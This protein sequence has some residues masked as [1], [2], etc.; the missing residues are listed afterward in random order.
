MDVTSALKLAAVVT[1][2]GDNDLA[3]AHIDG[4]YLS[5]TDG[6]IQFD[7][8]IDPPFEKP[9]TVVADAVAKV[10]AKLGNGD[11]RTFTA[12]NV[13]FRNGD[14]TV[15]TPYTMPKL[16]PIRDARAEISRLESEQLRIALE[17]AG[18]HTA[19]EGTFAAV[20][21][22]AGHMMATDTMRLC[23]IPFAGLDKVVIPSLIITKLISLFRYYKES[24]TVSVREL[25]GGGYQ[26]VTPDF[27][28]S[29]PPVD[30][31]RLPDYRAFFAADTTATLVLP[32]ELQVLL[33]T[34][35][36]NETVRFV[37][38]DKSLVAFVEKT[39]M[40][41]TVPA[42]SKDKVVIHLRAGNVT[43]IAKWEDKDFLEFELFE[44]R[45]ST[46]A[47]AAV[48][49]C[50]QKYVFRPNTGEKEE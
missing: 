14:V 28:I 48:V 6:F 8:E 7:A 23:A 11:K 21:A 35:G 22:D 20:F 18:A 12:N 1:V 2:R 10:L 24:V 33:E 46:G 25:P 26:F 37:Q 34:V 19:A 40:Q 3:L 39:G 41:F 15:A 32:R 36:K 31:L 47:T 17:I 50:A 45:S 42:I 13:V 16:S 38:D 43:D 9:A 27:T 5:A 29:V 4:P 49:R 30:E 44:S